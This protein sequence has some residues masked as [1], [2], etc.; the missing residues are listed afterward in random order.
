MEVLH[1]NQ[2][3]FAN[4][5]SVSE[6]TLEPD[7]NRQIWVKAGRVKPDAPALAALVRIC[8]A[9]CGRVPAPR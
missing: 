8:P 7:G 5:W 1:L 2:K 9:A 4:R 6:A 3:Q